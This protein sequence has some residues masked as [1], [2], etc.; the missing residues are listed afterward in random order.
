MDYRAHRFF[1]IHHLYL[2]S[3]YKHLVA[4]VHCS[5]LLRHRYRSQIG[6]CPRLCRRMRSCQS[7]GQNGDDVA[8]LDSF[9]L[10]V[11]V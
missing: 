9:R 7:Q 6:Y 2:V 1:R 10:V 11:A 4:F 5:I 8:D 3:P